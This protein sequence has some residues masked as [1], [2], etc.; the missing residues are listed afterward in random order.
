M[1]SLQQA[2][3][4]LPRTGYGAPEEIRQ[5]SAAAPGQPVDLAAPQQDGESWP[6][7]A[8]GVTAEVPFAAEACPLAE[9]DQG[10]YLALSQGSL[11][12]GSAVVL[13]GCG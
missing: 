1:P 12:A 7:A 11:G 2:G 9:D 6:Q 3:R 8:Y 10:D 4:R 13:G 5:G